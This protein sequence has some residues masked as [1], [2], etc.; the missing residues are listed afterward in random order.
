MKVGKWTPGAY[1]TKQWENSPMRSH[2]RSGR[3]L[4]LDG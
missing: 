1:T 2:L 4:G 3:N